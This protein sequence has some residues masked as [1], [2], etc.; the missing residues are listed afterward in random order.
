MQRA[1]HQRKGPPPYARSAI[2]SNGPVVTAWYAGGMPIL[3]KYDAAWKQLPKS[4]DVLLPDISKI[5]VVAGQAPVFSLLQGEYTVVAAEI[6]QLS[7]Q[8]ALGSLAVNVGM[9]IKETFDVVL[10]AMNID[11]KSE[12]RSKL[13]EGGKN[14]L[15]AWRAIHNGGEKGS[16]LAAISI[17]TGVGV[18]VDTAAIIPVVG[19]IIKALWNVGIAI[20]NIAKL[21]KESGRGPADVLYSPTTFDPKL[22]NVVVNAVLSDL[23]GKH[24]WGRRWGPPRMGKGVGTTPD[25]YA[26]HLEGGGLEIVRKAG[27]VA[28]PGSSAI[29]WA[30]AGWLGM[31][32]GTPYLHQGIQVRKGGNVRDMGEILLP[33]AQGILLWLWGAVLGH[34]GTATP[35]MWCVDTEDLGVWGQYILDLHEFIH[36]DLDVSDSTKQRI[37]DHYNKRGNQKVFAWGSSI[38]PKSNEWDNYWPVKQAIDLRARQMG[39]LDTLQCAYVDDSFAAIAKS[40]GMRERWEQRRKQ[41]LT[42]PARCDVDLSN[43]PDS[44]YRDALID[45][46]AK[47]GLCKIGSMQLSAVTEFTPPVAM[48]EGATYATPPPSRR[49]RKGKGLPAAVPFVALTAAG[50]WAWKT[51]KLSALKL[52]KLRL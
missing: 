2:P 39:M 46:G 38:K 37:I 49:K 34:G 4:V 50:Y 3:P 47:S 10:D 43:V 7:S 17:E 48:P 1:E 13:K 5:A 8:V 36:A 19:W 11:V 16:A 52:P 41:L 9:P 24:S 45:S 40:P 27:H 32:P 30:T 15:E 44:V 33:S 20:K 26:Y 42:H 25:F 31:I 35:S 18:A 12:L 23:S 28:G 51:G 6:Y 29:D 14:L 21:V 22:D